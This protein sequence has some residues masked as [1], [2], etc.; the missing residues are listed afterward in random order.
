MVVDRRVHELEADPHP[1]LRAGPVAVA[2]DGVPRPREANEA[3]R[4]LRDF[5]LVFRRYNPR[6]MEI[7]DVAAAAADEISA[8][9]ARERERRTAA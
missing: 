1:L 9:N 8:R 5:A 7:M 3:V 4:D 2:G 6:W